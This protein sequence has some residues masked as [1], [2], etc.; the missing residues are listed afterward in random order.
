MTKLRELQKVAIKIYINTVWLPM[1]D[2]HDTQ[3]VI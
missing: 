3:A 1:C 2:G